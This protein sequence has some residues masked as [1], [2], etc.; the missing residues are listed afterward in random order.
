MGRTLVANRL[1]AGS[2]CGKRQRGRPLNAIVRQHQMASEA[3]SMA[4]AWVA[5]WRQHESTGEFPDS[6]ASE[7]VNDLAHDDPSEALAVILEILRSIEPDPE[8]ELFQV[9]A[10]GPV[11]DLLAN[12]GDAIIENVEAE[13]SRNEAF[14]LLLGGVWKNTM[15]QDIWERV[16]RCR[17]GQW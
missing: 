8:T 2:A 3:K 6:E 5:Y 17:G 15:S 13:A 1:L 12:S 4:R 10:A 11:E 14:K 9:L 7:V 16:E